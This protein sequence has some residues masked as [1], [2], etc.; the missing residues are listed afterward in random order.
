MSGFRYNALNT[1]YATSFLIKLLNQ[2][3]STVKSK[4]IFVSEPFLPP[5]DDLSGHLQQIWNNKWVTNNGV[6]HQQLEAKLADHLGV[7]YISLFAN[8]TVALLCA[9][10]VASFKRKVITTPFSFV[11]TS[12][13][14]AFL[15]IEPVFVDIDPNTLNI[16]PLKVAEAIDNDVTGI[17]PVHCYGNPCDV[18]VLQTI[19]DEH[20][21]DIIYDSAH[22]FGVE[23]HC[24]SILNHGRFSVLS[25][26]ATKVFNTFEGGAVVSQTMQDKIAIDRIKN[27]S[28]VDQLNIDSVGINGK[29]SEF[30]AA[31]GIVQLNYI[32]S[33]I[34]ARM[35]ISDA[36]FKLL[37][38]CNLLTPINFGT[39]IK[40]NYAYFPVVCNDNHIRET[41]YDRLTSNNVYVR[42]YF[43]PLISNFPY[44]AK[45]NSANKSNLPVANTL[46]DRILCLPIH[47][48]IS[49][50]DIEFICKIIYQG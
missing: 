17:L 4:K 12:H 11:A 1:L 50:K 15:G 30:N 40:H 41:L 14:L 22:A 13:A 42:K 45:I 47:S 8:C 49:I 34:T 37:K 46:A 44:Y 38:D 48:G 18:D 20:K 29:M 27:F 5:I 10:K 33:V 31:L 23:C 35:K 2:S 28:F 32:D 6:F 25:F 26:H 16:D 7:P 36:Y 39:S 24:G 3:I 9:I 43:Y 19:A 21:I